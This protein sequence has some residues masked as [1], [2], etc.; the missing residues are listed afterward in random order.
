M[1]Q[2]ISFIFR[3]KNCSELPQ[4]RTYVLHMF[5]AVSLFLSQP[6]YGCLTSYCNMKYSENLTHLSDLLVLFFFGE[7]ATNGKQIAHYTHCT[8]LE[9]HITHHTTPSQ[10]ER[11]K[12][13]PNSAF[14][15]I[16]HTLNERKREIEGE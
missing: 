11:L 15:S 3:N 8:A 14:V 9:H 6:L 12:S 16:R 1:C 5:D 7:R 10:S 4:Y 2:K 13:N